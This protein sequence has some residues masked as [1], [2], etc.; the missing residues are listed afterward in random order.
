MLG[1][2]F[3]RGTFGAFVLYT[4]AASVHAADWL[5]IT[6]RDLATES[7]PKAPGA[8][9]IYLYRQVDRD[10]NDPSETV[11]YRIKVLTEEGR[12]YADIE[13]PYD[14]RKERVRSIEARTVRP[15]GSIADFDGTVFEKPLIRGRGTKLFA[16]TFTLPDVQV[17]S[18]I[19]YRYR[20]DLPYGYVYNSR[21]LLSDDLFTKHAKFSLSQYLDFSLRYSWPAGLPEGTQPPK[22]EQSRIRLETHDVP[23][24]VSEDYM[25]PA[26]EMKYRV[27]FVYDSEPMMDK[28]PAD[29]W[30]KVGK[31]RYRIVDDYIDKRRAMEQALAQIVAPD[32]SPEVKLRKIYARTQQIRNLSYERNKSE[33]EAAREA[34]KDAKN[35][36]DVW[37]LG[38]GYGEEITWLFLALA[39]TAGFDAHPVLVSTRDDYFFN[40][41]LMNERQLNSNVVV[42]NLDGKELYFDPGTSLLPFG[43]LPWSETA[44]KGLRLDKSG[45]TWVSTPLPSA[46]EARTERRAN[47]KLTNRGTLEGKLTVTYTGLEALWRRLQQRNEDDA[48]RKEFIEDQ[49]KRDIPVG[50]DVTLTNEPQWD[51]SDDS[52]VVEYDLEVPGWAAAAGQRALLPVGLFGNREKHIFKHA[53]RVHPLYF[54]F[55]YKT[56]DDITIELPKG[57]QVES[58][59][60]ARNNN[61]KVLEF[62]SS[63]QSKEGSLHIKRELAVEMLLVDKKFYNQ[64][65]EFFRA[66]KASDEEQIVIGPPKIPAKLPAKNAGSAGS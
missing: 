48:E 44:V 43:K 41:R 57:W 30:K 61:L 18:I 33:Q 25:P 7:E 21:W 62:T 40:I 52:L 34:Q 11:Y 20:H 8:S 51:S 5:P 45:G 2:T 46:S 66:V 26:D 37:N 55:P 59:P 35:V 63:A 17:G 58:L 13:I 54:S 10:D 29:F 6:P 65:R 49:I 53:T 39:R 50:I 14:K 22:R 27:D 60:A 64:V 12:K 28:E 31:K 47:L 16:K 42:V 36:A 38:Y 23:A 1:K 4:L 3:V 9:A 19:E 32:D 15:D 56:L 24:F